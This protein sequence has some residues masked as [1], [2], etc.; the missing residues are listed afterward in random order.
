M[1]LRSVSGV[2]WPSQADAAAGSSGWREAVR[3]LR[4]ADGGG[5]RWGDRRRS[6]CGDLRRCPWCV[7]LH[8]RRG[9]LDAGTGGLDWRA[10]QRAGGGR[11]RAAADRQRQ[12]QVWDHQGLLFRAGGEPDLRR[13]GG[14]LWHGDHPGTPR[15]A[16]RQSQGGS[17]CP[18]GAALDLARLRNR[19]F[20]S[21]AELN[22]AIR[23]LVADINDRPMRVGGRPG[24]RCSSSSI[25]RPCCRLRRR[26]MNTRTGS[27]AVSAW[28]I[29][30]RSAGISTRCRSS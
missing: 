25:D 11:R 13:H 12:S 28:T 8:L 18:G 9:N 3:R 7:Q 23:E 15:Q 14:A 1:V 10:C 5:I 17:W 24:G 16:A 6:A 27:A 21:L 29:M 19:R 2:G 30:S 4:R 26:P 22:G 20:F